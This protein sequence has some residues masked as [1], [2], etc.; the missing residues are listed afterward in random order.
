MTRM[1][2]QSVPRAKTSTSGMTK[3]R[4]IKGSEKFL[5][6]LYWYV[7]TPDVTNKCV[8]RERF[9]NREVTFEDIHSYLQKACNDSSITLHYAVNDQYVEI[10]TTGQLQ[11][12]LDYIRDMA[13][14]ILYV[15]N[16]DF[17]WKV[18]DKKKGSNCDCE[19]HCDYDPTV[20]KRTTSQGCVDGA[21]QC[22][23][24]S[25]SNVSD[26]SDEDSAAD[27]ALGN[28]ENEE[29]SDSQ[30]CK[31]FVDDATESEDT[32]SEPGLNKSEDD[33]SSVSSSDTMSLFKPV[34]KPRCEPTFVPQKKEILIKAEYTAPPENPEDFEEL[35][36]NLLKDDV[37]CF[38]FASFAVKEMVSRLADFALG[39]LKL[40]SRER[41]TRN[42]KG[43]NT[44]FFAMM[45]N[46]I[47]YYWR[48]KSRHDQYVTLQ[49]VET[50]VLKVVQIVLEVWVEEIEKL[51]ENMQTTEE[52]TA[53][54]AKKI[55]DLVFKTLRE[56]FKRV[57]IWQEFVYEL[58]A[59]EHFDFKKYIVLG[60]LENKTKATEIFKTMLEATL[61]NIEKVLETIDSD[62]M[63]ENNCQCL[64]AIPE[65]L[66]ELKQLIKKNPMSDPESSDSVESWDEWKLDS[67][68]QITGLKKSCCKSHDAWTMPGTGKKTV[69]KSGLKLQV[70]NGAN[71]GEKHEE[72]SPED[73][74]AELKLQALQEENRALLANLTESFTEK[75]TSG[76]SEEQKNEL[77]KLMKTQH[78]YV[79]PPL[80]KPGIIMVPTGGLARCRCKK[81]CKFEINEPAMAY[82]ERFNEPRLAVWEKTKQ[83]RSKKN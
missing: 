20:S 48:R 31:V 56:S 29:I 50:A 11:T 44:C 8:V 19:C 77:K 73:L 28:E 83:K 78:N 15:E 66:R 13:G 36:T 41:R 10:T 55:S 22:D 42:L 82:F 12:F 49:D 75:K 3:N 71:N 63:Q 23:C 65:K 7:G 79:Y 35:F 64:E 43:I 58:G 60:D 54:A 53:Q 34:K 17:V 9:L 5:T 51:A 59:I 32:S 69:T 52:W 1:V 4:K 46:L 18:T 74:A 26:S 62:W 33:E 14:K 27:V 2:F 57:V 6:I 21:S 72:T 70:Q 24:A 80:P 76:L 25:E 40:S 16:K 61:L 38:D 37:S 81:D 68:E 45:Q 30:S 39:T 67:I 47:K